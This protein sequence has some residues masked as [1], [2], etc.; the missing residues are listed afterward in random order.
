MSSL[1]SDPVGASFTDV[2][3]SLAA[4]SIVNESAKSVLERLLSAIKTWTGSP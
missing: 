2:A 4:R 1:M 3:L